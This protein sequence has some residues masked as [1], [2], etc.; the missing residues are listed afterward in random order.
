M[1][2]RRRTSKK[3]KPINYVPTPGRTAP[4]GSNSFTLSEHVGCNYDKRAFME[5]R[6]PL[7]DACLNGHAKLPTPQE[8]G[9]LS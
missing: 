8:R 3:V 2:K 4:H 9:R 1:A 6:V 5:G 7:P